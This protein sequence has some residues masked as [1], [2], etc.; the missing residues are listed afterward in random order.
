[1]I[2]GDLEHLEIVREEDR[3]Q[4]GE[5]QIISATNG[6][7]KGEAKAS[8]ERNSQ[9]GSLIQRVEERSSFTSFFDNENNFSDG[10]SIFDIVLELS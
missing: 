10:S 6:A 2:I 9:V 5:Q 3:I 4:G 1:M 7:A 8:V